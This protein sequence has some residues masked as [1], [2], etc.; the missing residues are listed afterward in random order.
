MSLLLRV[1]TIVMMNGAAVMKNVFA[2][3][4]KL[5]NVP[6]QKVGENFI[7][8]FTACRCLDLVEGGTSFEEVV[9]LAQAIEKQVQPL[10]IQ[11]LAR[12]KHVS[13]RL[14]LPKSLAQLL[15]G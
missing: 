7:I 14:L 2:S 1:P 12:M 3:Q 15:H 13:Q 11:G 5:L 8:I 10:S 4:L 6:V 9:Q